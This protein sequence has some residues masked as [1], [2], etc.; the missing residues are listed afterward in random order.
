MGERTG[1]GLSLCIM[2][3]SVTPTNSTSGGALRNLIDHVKD[4]AVRSAQANDENDARHGLVFAVGD[5]AQEFFEKE[6]VVVP[7][8]VQGLDGLCMV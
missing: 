5:Q 8:V 1:S 6:M 3:D 7:F 4:L 2:G